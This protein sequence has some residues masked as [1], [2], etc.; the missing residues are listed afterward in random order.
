M[1]RGG[2]VERVFERSLPEHGLDLV[3]TLDVAMQQAALDELRAQPWPGALVLLELPDLEIRVLASWPERDRSELVEWGLAETSDADRAL[4]PV[5]PRAWRPYYPPALGSVIKPLIAATAMR[6]GRLSPGRRFDCSYDQLIADGRAVRCLG[7]HGSIGLASAIERSCNH[8]F[9]LLAAEV[10]W[11]PWFGWLEEF[12]FG[13]RTGFANAVFP[14]LASFEPSNLVPAE[15]E[16]GLKHNELRTL[17]NLMLFGFGQG[18][19]DDVTPL[20]VAAAMAALAMDRYVP[21]RLIERAGPHSPRPAAPRPLRIPAGA[22]QAVVDGMRAV[23]GPT[24]SARPGAVEGLDLSSY[25]LATKTGT[26]QEGGHSDSSWFAGFLP[27]GQP[28]FAFA[29]FLE[30]THAHGGHVCAPIL[31]RLLEHPAFAEVR[32]AARAGR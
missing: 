20:Q 10:G 17:R 29:L 26:P 2:E 31:Q 32:E 15:A 28:R 30:R 24:G 13:E 18:A 21:P 22:R 16:C 14:D 11:A 12:G 3:L 1:D 23:T 19:I 8:Y 9:A 27:S 6:D 25:D 5:H 4:H 7:S